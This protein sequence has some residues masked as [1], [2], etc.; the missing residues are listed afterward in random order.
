MPITALNTKKTLVDRRMHCQSLVPEFDFRDVIDIVSQY[1]T[2]FCT[3][4][5]AHRYQFIM[6]RHIFSRYST[7]F[8]DHIPCL[9]VSHC[10]DT[11]I[12]QCQSCKSWRMFTKWQMYH[13]FTPYCTTGHL[14]IWPV[15]A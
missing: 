12:T 14:S 9:Q 3:S 2:Q 8:T 5:Q 10:H 6:Y 11:C 15:L 1:V 7:E 13:H 4:T